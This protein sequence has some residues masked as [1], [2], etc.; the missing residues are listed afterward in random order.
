MV[1]EIARWLF[2]VQGEIEWYSVV[3]GI[4]GCLFVILEV[5]ERL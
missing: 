2:V 1:L 5:V 4:L 3:H